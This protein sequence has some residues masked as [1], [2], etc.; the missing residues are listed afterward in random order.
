MSCAAPPFPRGRE[1]LDRRS[2]PAA[3]PPDGR[4][5]SASPGN[6]VERRAVRCADPLR[7]S[8][9]K[10]NEHPTRAPIT[11]QPRG[12][13]DRLTLHS[14]DH[15][16]PSHPTGDPEHAVLALLHVL[17]GDHG[18][19]LAGLG[20]RPAQLRPRS[21][22]TSSLRIAARNWIT[23][24]DRVIPRRGVQHPA[25]LAQQ[26]GMPGD[27]IHVP[28]CAGLPA[29]QELDRRRSVRLDEMREVIATRGRTSSRLP[30]R[31]CDVCPSC[32]AVRS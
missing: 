3:S 29:D 18:E 32:W 1:P 6:Q 13:S 26:A 25:S 14:G 27:R 8:S 17:T 9:S 21:A 24:G 7:T 2:S 20:D 28:Q 30:A 12:R 5:P 19:Q 22:A 11:T 10:S 31:R 16:V 4:R 15:P 23:G